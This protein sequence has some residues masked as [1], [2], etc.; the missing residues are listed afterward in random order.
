M[1]TVIK[2][3]VAVAITFIGFS[4]LAAWAVEFL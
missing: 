4:V 3:V 1:S 2:S